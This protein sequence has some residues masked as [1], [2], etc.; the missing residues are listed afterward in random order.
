MR[1]V[2]VY[3]KDGTKTEY[4]GDSAKNLVARG[5][6]DEDQDNKVAFHKRILDGCR[7]AELDGKLKCT[8]READFFKSVHTEA[9]RHGGDLPSRGSFVQGRAVR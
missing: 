9:A 5:A 7:E 1:T 4:S 2:I 6:K 3:H 8:R